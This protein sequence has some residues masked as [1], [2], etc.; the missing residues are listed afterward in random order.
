MMYRVALRSKLKAA[1]LNAS[2]NM[3]NF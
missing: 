3:V 1:L 2:C